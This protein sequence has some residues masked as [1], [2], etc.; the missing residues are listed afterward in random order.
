MDYSSYSKPKW[1]ANIVVGA[2][3]WILFVYGIS[4]AKN[5]HISYTSLLFFLFGY[6]LYV[7][8]KEVLKL[9]EYVFSFI[10]VPFYASQAEIN[11]NRLTP[12]NLAIT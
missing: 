5:I 3:C 12:K 10:Y 6:Q 2:I 8:I 1:V 9:R 4:A 7:S 11:L